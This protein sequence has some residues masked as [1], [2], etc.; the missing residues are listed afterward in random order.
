MKYQDIP[1]IIAPI[2]LAAGQLIM[3]IAIRHINHVYGDISG[4]FTQFLV[5]KMPDMFLVQPLGMA[6][7]LYG[8]ENILF[9]S[10]WPYFENVI[11]LSYWTEKV[12]NPKLPLIMRPFGFP[13]LDNEDRENILGI[14]TA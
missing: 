3:T 8:S 6:K 1:F 5:D 11:Q 13:S 10:N 4:F 7:V 2:G 14:N 9:G 12:K